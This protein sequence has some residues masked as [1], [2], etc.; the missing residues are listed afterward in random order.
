MFALKGP[1]M[2]AKDHAPNF[3]LKHAHKDMD[4]A[5]Q[6]ANEAG[7]EFSVTQ[8]AEEVFRE[9]RENEELQ[10]ADEDFSAVYEMIHKKSTNNGNSKKIRFN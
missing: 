3:P 10:L 4:L 2:V 8:Q 9:A 7:V 5:V 1:K 6:M